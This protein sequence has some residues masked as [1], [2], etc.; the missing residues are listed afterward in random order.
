VIGGGKECPLLQHHYHQR[1]DK[2]LRVQRPNEESKLESKNSNNN[3]E[4]KGME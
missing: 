2:E 3:N 1:K 4:S